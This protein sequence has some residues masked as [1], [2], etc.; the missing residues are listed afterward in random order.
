VPAKINLLISKNRSRFFPTFAVE[1]ADFVPFGYFSKASKR[2]RG[3]GNTHPT[4]KNTQLMMW[5]CRLICPPGGTILDP[6][7]GSG[8]TALAAVRQGFGFV[9]VEENPEYLAIAERR[10]ADE[11]ARTPLLA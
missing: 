7:L 10:L 8:S 4:A 11:R 1:A 3:Q 6:F 5:L 2:D 9:G